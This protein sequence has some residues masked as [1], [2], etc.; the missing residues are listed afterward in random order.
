M[1]RSPLRRP[2]S[3]GTPRQRQIGSGATRPGDLCQV[4]NLVG[5]CACAQFCQA[6]RT[7]AAHASV[8]FPSAGSAHR[9]ATKCQR[10]ARCC[11]RRST[12]TSRR[13]HSHAMQRTFSLPGA[14]QE[15]WP[16][17]S[18]CDI[19]CPLSSNG[20]KNVETLHLLNSGRCLEDKAGVNECGRLPVPPPAIQTSRPAFYHGARVINSVITHEG[21]EAV[22]F[23]PG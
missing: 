20:T 2:P 21:V 22:S 3:N 9:S 23:G 11:C 13:S 16:R 18:I 17:H 6:K 4:V 19:E 12:A 10:R 5:L 7:W 15:R 8:C 14:H 1:C